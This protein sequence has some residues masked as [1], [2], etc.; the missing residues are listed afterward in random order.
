V[1]DAVEIEGVEDLLVSPMSPVAVAFHAVLL[2]RLREAIEESQPIDSPDVD[3]LGQQWLVPLVSHRGAWFEAAPLDSAFLWR[4]YELLDETNN[5][6]RVRNATFISNRIAFFLSVHPFLGGPDGRVAITCVSPGD[7]RPVIQALRKLMSSDRARE[8]GYTRPQIDLTLVGASENVR[9]VLG[10]VASGAADAEVDRIIRTRCDI[11]LLDELPQS[12]FSHLTFLFQT[13]G[14][15]GTGPV[16]LSERAPTT[17][18]SSLATRLGRSQQLQSDPTFVSGVF[19]A[20][21]ALDSA[22]LERIQYRL[23]ELVGGQGGERLAHGWTRM[24]RAR[25]RAD[26]L[27]GWYQN[28]AW[29]VHLDRMIGIEAFAHAESETSILEYEDSADTSAIGY[30]GITATRHVEPYVAAL[31]RAVEDLVTLE[32]ETGRALMRQLESVSGRWTLQIVQRPLRQ[33]RE[34][35]GTACAVDFLTRAEAGMG[36]GAGVLRCLVALE[37][38]VPG[39]P[40]SGIPQRYRD[41]RRGTGAMCD[42]LLLI[43][44]SAGVTG[45]P[46]VGAAV[47]EVKFSSVGSPD[48]VHAAA[49]VEETNTWLNNRFGAGA[50]SLDLRGAELSELIRSASARNAAFG[51]GT[52]LAEAEERLLGNVARGEYDLAI[53]LLRG[54]RHRRGMVISVEASPASGASL[55]QL[56]GPNG[57]LD[58]VTLGREWIEA[59]LN[60]EYPERGAGW[61]PVVPGPPSGDRGAEAQAVP[62]ADETREEPADAGRDA[63][64][65]ARVSIP[66]ARPEDVAEMAQRLDRAFARYALPIEGFDPALALQGPSVIRYRSRG[67]GRLAIGDVERRARDLSRE[68]EASAAIHIGQEPG[69]ITVDV[70]RHDRQ[71]VPLLAV[72]PFLERPSRAGALDFVA[73]VSP[74]GEVRVADLSNLPHLLV[75]GATGSGKSVFL[76]GLLVELVRAR[77]PD[78]LHLI[79]VDPKRLDFAPFAGLPHLRGEILNDADEALERLQFTLAA[80]IDLRQPIL[81]AAGASSAAEF[82]EAGG[83]LEE[84][85]QLVIVIDE[86]ADLVLAG[87]DRRAFSEMIQRYAQLTRAYGIFLVLATQRPSVD[88]ITGSIKANLTARAA[89]ALPS[90]RD[91]MTILDQAGAEDLLGDGDLLFYRSGRVERLQAPLA[92]LADVRGLN[93]GQQP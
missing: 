54:S 87:T 51:L 28:A 41:S 37:E 63:T 43:E 74:A 32:S 76:R 15:R 7:G 47:V 31:K 52:G 42:D 60:G 68:V 21:P 72:L 84:L 36:R 45:R 82:Y 3:A 89:F 26:D 69:Y 77:T 83:S 46:V 8:S 81:Q 14:G 30:D 29:V 1:I 2:A 44:V 91:S 10:E 20:E 53:G 65:A 4:R 16:A 12:D 58:L 25:A 9:D 61:A 88:V 35:I 92:T 6:S 56:N 79:I 78:Q 39:F 18:A 23:L 49:Q 13:P 73:G 57:P 27:E 22:P 34:R 70:P 62:T 75:A 33:V 80:E 38:L 11:R 40:A 90:Y 55:S 19:A 67:V 66:L 17:F 85:P 71:A 64:I 5:G 86:F 50:Q 59:V 48:F 93:S 24:I